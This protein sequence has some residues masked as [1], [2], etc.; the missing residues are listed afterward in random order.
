[1]PNLKLDLSRF[2]A[3]VR[4]LSGIVNDGPGIEITPDGRIIHVPGGPGDPQVFNSAISKLALAQ[5]LEHGGAIASSAELQAAMG[6]LA[7]GLKAEAA[8]SI[9]A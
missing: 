5:V 7:V 1:M 3:S 2:Q 4:I 6:R 9:A 8:K